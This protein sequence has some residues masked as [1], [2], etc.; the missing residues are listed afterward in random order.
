MLETVFGDANLDGVFNS[1]DLQFVFANGEF[2][3]T[4]LLNSSWDEGDWNGDCEF[5]SDDL[6]FVL[7]F[8]D[9]T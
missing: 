8:F 9:P 2:E 3:D 1:S 7:E 4:L 6:D 5:D